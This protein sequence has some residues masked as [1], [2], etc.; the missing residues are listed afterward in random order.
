M[1]NWNMSIQTIDFKDTERDLVALGNVC[2]ELESRGLPRKE[3]TA[4]VLAS[5]ANQA[6]ANGMSPEAVIDALHDIISDNGEKPET[7]AARPARRV[8]AITPE[9]AESI[10]SQIKLLQNFLLYFDMIICSEIQR[11]A[12]QIL[13]ELKE[14]GMYRH[15]LKRYA[16]KL[17]DEARVLQMRVKDNDRILVFKWVRRMDPKAVY[18]KKYHEQGGSVLSRMVLAYRETF[19]RLWA[20]VELDCRTVARQASAKVAD[21]VAMLLKMEALTN[22]GIELYDSCVKRMKALV[23]GHGKASITKSTHHESMRCA[24]HNLLRQLGVRLDAAG[25]TEQDYARRHLTDL[26]RAMVEE[27]MGDFFQNEFDRM[28]EEFVQYMT[29]CM[30][31]GL[32]AGKLETGAVRLVYERLGTKKKVRKFFKHLA[33]VPMPGGDDIDPFD[34]ADAIAEYGGPRSEIDRFARMCLSG[35]KA[36][37][38]EPEDIQEQRMLRI[39][40]RRNGGMLPDDIL[41]VMMMKRRTKKSVMEVL[42]ASG[43]ELAATLRRVKGMK[44]AELKQL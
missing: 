29:A 31:M 13:Q 10:R 19:G 27:G 34:V 36:E 14:K 23:A 32:Q 40:A 3:A 20:V 8:S 24:T 35:E 6:V 11:Y 42:S 41:R 30:R 4:H 21:I 15:E 37:Q 44:A 2:R 25:K 5:M 16:N 38:T 12:F 7:R 39:L 1:T 18:G 43:F 17:V 22:T 33:A 26:Q 28:G 9:R